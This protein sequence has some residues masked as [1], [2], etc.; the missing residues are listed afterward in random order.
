MQTPI[1]F[2]V[3]EAAD[4][5]VRLSVEDGALRLRGPRRAA[6]LAAAL[7]KREAEVIAYLRTACSRCYGPL[8]FEES[9]RAGL[10][11]TCRLYGEVDVA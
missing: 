2:L 3:M 1:R 11:T 9:L 6:F 4:A 7:R 8:Y 5:G 10:C